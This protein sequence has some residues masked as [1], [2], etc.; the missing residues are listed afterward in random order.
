MLL[1]HVLKFSRGTEKN[2]VKTQSSPKALK[3]K[4]NHLMLVG[5]IDSPHFQKWLHV[6]AQE[7]PNKK[8]FIFPSDRPRF[9]TFKE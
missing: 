8:I 4:A 2:L 7:F 6:V 9:Y 5:M 3:L 1:M